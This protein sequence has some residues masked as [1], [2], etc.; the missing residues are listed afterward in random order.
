[1]E[2]LEDLEG[3]LKERTPLYEKYADVTVDA[4]GLDAELVAA[5]ITGILNS[6][7]DWDQTD[8]PI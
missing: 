7:P 3:L 8:A 1:M 5:E 6:H 2:P 4:D